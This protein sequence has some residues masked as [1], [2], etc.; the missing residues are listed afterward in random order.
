MNESVN[1]SQ[2]NR[3]VVAGP[4]RSAQDA[5]LLRRGP[6]GRPQAPRQPLRPPLRQPLG[7]R[8]LRPGAR[9]RPRLHHP[10]EAARAA[11]AGVAFIVLAR[12]A[13]GGDRPNYRRRRVWA[14][15]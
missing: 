1:I 7:V 9:P 8:P 10:A 5:N 3:L 2:P 14:I 13:L 6:P 4:C 15:N 11:V 12:Y